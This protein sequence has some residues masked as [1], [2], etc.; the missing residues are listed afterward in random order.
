MNVS[1]QALATQ[2]LIIGGTTKAATTSLYRYLD[3]RPDICASTIKETRFFIDDDYPLSPLIAAK[4]SEG[5]EK[6]NECFPKNYSPE[7]LRLEASPDY[8]YS[9]GTPAR[10]KKYLPNAKIVFIL[11]EPISRLISWYKFAKQKAYIPADISFTE[12]VEKQLESGRLETAKAEKRKSDRVDFVPQSFYFSTLEQ[13]CYSKYLKPYFEALGRENVCIVFYEQ[14][15]SDPKSVLKEICDFAGIDPSF[16]D[17]YNFEVF[18]RSQTMKSSNIHAIYSNCLNGVRKYT[19][20]LPIR[21]L[22]RATRQWFDSTIYHPLNTRPQEK[23]EIYST[24]ESKLKNYY[25]NEIKEL[26]KLLDRSLPW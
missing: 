25:Q 21:P 3:D 12:Y 19:H 13:G 5:I 9:E 7:C 24:L 18:N 23:V 17:N 22:L 15:C 1:Q 26:E 20:K 4:W 16:Y 10:I 14:L 2:Y 8:L 11:R 6:Y